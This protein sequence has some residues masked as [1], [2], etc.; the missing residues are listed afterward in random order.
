[1]RAVTG[2]CWFCGPPRMPLHPESLSPGAV[3]PSRSGNSWAT[4]QEALHAGCPQSH[5]N[6]CSGFGY[7]EGGIFFFFF[8]FQPF[9]KLAPS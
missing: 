4:A 5:Q 8:F 9:R 1:M 3:A 2:M 7:R 6:L